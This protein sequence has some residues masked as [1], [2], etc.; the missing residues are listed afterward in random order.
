MNERF[1]CDYNKDVRNTRKN[2]SGIRTKPGSGEAHRGKRQENSIKD[3]F[4]TPPP[5]FAYSVPLLRGTTSSLNGIF[6]GFIP[7]RSFNVSQSCVYYSIFPRGFTLTCAQSRPW[8][9]YVKLFGSKINTLIAC[10]TIEQMARA[11]SEVIEWEKE[12]LCTTS[13]VLRKWNRNRPWRTEKS[14]R[15]Q[16]LLSRWR[17]QRKLITSGKAQGNE[18]GN[19]N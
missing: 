10:N 18:N 9:D 6:I 15:R 2:T 4:P 19:G 17:H 5:L 13:N 8:F 14:A 1:S 11:R 12:K 16:K 3:S 7:E